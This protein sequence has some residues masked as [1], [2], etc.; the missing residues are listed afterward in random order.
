MH[1]Y[2]TATEGEKREVVTCSFMNVGQGS[3]LSVPSPRL[4][5]VRTVE[6]WW[7]PPFLLNS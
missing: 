4:R 5:A 2:L 6:T 7:S 1:R 3:P